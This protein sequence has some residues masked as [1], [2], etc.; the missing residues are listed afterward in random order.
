MDEI[1]KSILL[2]RDKMYELFITEDKT[3]LE[4]ANILDVSVWSVKEYLNKKHGIYKSLINPDPLQHITKQFLSNNDW[5]EHE[6]LTKRKS[7]N[8][9]ANELG[10]SYGRVDRWIEKHGFYGLKTYK[11]T[12]NENRFSFKD[13]IFCY[14]A[15]YVATDGHIDSSTTPRVS[16][17]SSDRCSEILFKNLSTYF[18]FTGNVRL[19]NK[20][21]DL[22]ITSQKLVDE[23][24]KY[25][26]I[27]PAKTQ[28]LRFPGYFYNDVCASMFMRG[29]ID[30]DGNIKKDGTV[31]LYCGSNEFIEGCILFLE[32]RFNWRINKTFVRK[33][34]PGFSLSATKSKHLLEWIYNYNRTYLLQ[35]KYELYLMVRWPKKRYSFQNTNLNN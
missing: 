11:N 18:E 17:R 21:Y 35:R 25:F 33:K 1:A 29:V 23:L 8:Q 28:T 16:I 5:L 20:S 26:Y 32:A 13:P 19:Y 30:D 24:L 27:T 7:A 22:T 12:C 3:L 4:I 2:D 14:Y 15:G 9:I 31:R 34:Y 6:Y 10:V